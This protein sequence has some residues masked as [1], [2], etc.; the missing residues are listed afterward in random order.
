MDGIMEDF[1][2]SLMLESAVP[3]QEM[4][5]SMTN[6]MLYAEQYISDIIDNNS[7]VKI[8]Y[9]I[10]IFF[11][12]LLALKVLKKGFSVYI[13]WKDGDA[14][15]SPKEM[16]IS[17]LQAIV[18]AAAFPYLYDYLAQTTFWLSDTIIMLLFGTAP[19]L[20]YPLQGLWD[21]L[22]AVPNGLF[23]ALMSVVYIICLIIFWFQILRR[24][25]EMLILRLGFPLACIGLIDSDSGVFKPYVKLIFQAALTIVV[26]VICFNLSL[27]LIKTLNS[28]F[29]IGAIAAAI[30]GPALLSTMLVGTGGSGNPGQKVHQS[31]M[32]YNAFKTFGKG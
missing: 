21:V 15:T 22:L 7:I 10:Y 20:E 12:S 24:S 11:L 26:Q 5:N 32:I 30:N 23:T 28:I 14:D 19:N 8:Y 9:A 2:N 29:A 27:M 17:I 1:L 16:L 13:L 31:V 4:F 18:T 25:I 3:M 6:L